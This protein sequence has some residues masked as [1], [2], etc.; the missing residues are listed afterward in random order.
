MRFMGLDI[1]DKRIGV[2]ISDPLGLT[3]QGISVIHRSSLDEDIRVIDR[4][5]KE[6]EVIQ[7]VCGLPKNMNGTI[8]EQAVRV[9]KFVAKLK[10]MV[11]I[12]VTTWDERL[13]TRA[14]DHAMIEG[15]L[16]RSKRKKRVDQVAASII[17]QSF[18][19]HRSLADSRDPK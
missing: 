19:N 1:G 9:Q 4:I 8:G 12:P 16:R 15:G 5:A 18:L 7:I 6:H 3:A 10:Q 14:A 2:A 17:L 13:S 11:C